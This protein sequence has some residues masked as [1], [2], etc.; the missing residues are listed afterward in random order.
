[1][2]TVP[3]PQ[4]YTA[5]AA[6][7]LDEAKAYLRIDTVEDDAALGDVLTRVCAQF[8]QT[9]E[10]GLVATGYTWTVEASD[11]PSGVTPLPLPGPVAG[12]TVTRATVDIS[13]QFSLTCTG[14]HHSQ[15]LLIGPLQIAD[16]VVVTSLAA[17]PALSRAIEDALLQL[18]VDWWERRG[19]TSDFAVSQMP[20]F[21]DRW[22]MSH[23]TPRC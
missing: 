8:D 18:T 11:Q 20:G 3:L 17:V 23:W 22:L 16:V 14:W 13:A 2:S 9:M 12:F 4:D 19:T 5:R 21:V 1:M 10:A 6:T 7:L 15:P